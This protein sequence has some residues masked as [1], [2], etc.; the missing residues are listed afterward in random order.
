MTTIKS[1]A[2]IPLAFVLLVLPI[3]ASYAQ[4]HMDLTPSLSITEEYDDNIY[5][6]NKNKISSYITMASPSLDFSLLSQHTQLVLEYTPTFV[7]YSEDNEDSTTRHSGIL[8]FVR[9]LSEHFRFNLSNTY[10]KSDDPLEE[11]EEILGARDSR[12]TYQRNTGNVSFSYLF[13]P[14]NSL[15]V[16]YQNTSLKNEDDDED[17]GRAERSYASL[18]YQINIKN[19]LELE[20]EYT[21]EDFWR[22]HASPSAPASDDFYGH[23]PTIRYIYNFAPHTS[24]ILGYNFTTRNFEGVEEDY[25]V[26]DSSIGFEHAFSPSHSISAGAGY[27]IQK[28]DFSSDESGLTYDLSISRQFEHGNIN[29]GGSGG[30]DE[31]TL[32][33]NATRFTRYWSTNVSAEYQILEP[34]SAFAIGSFRHDK[35]DEPNRKYDI[36]DWNCGLRWTFLR[37]FSLSLDYTYAER[38]DDISAESYTDNRVSFTLMA[39]RLYRW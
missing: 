36:I 37:W 24:G 39:S 38:N 21:R 34:L 19:R 15:T 9:D 2:Y 14:Q 26:H 27:F 3:Q 22:E 25:K 4:T 1:K 33:A 12:N 6:T 31:T 30:W 32:Q 13:G 5:L 10:V 18:T 17:D 29:I 16:G 23:R 35:E 8:T 11:T 28:N 20:Y 7:R